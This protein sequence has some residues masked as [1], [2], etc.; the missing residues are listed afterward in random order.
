MELVFWSLHLH[1]VGSV[2]CK[3]GVLHDVVVCLQ[4]LSQ[5]RVLSAAD[6]PSKDI[7]CVNKVLCRVHEC[8]SMHAWGQL[9]LLDGLTP[10][11]FPKLPCSPHVVLLMWHH[12]L[13]AGLSAFTILLSCL[14]LIASVAGVTGEEALQI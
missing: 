2:G 14:A 8:A 11:Y 12:A 5:L 7:P 4:L 6:C 10:A 9:V 13:F 3:M 1:G